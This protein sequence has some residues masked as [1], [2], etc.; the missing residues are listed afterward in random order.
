MTWE[1]ERSMVRSRAIKA[2]FDMN[3][4]TLRDPNRESPGGNLEDRVR[5]ESRPRK[6]DLGEK[7]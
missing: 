2:H 1:V 4:S 3:Y 7:C 6:N 5:S